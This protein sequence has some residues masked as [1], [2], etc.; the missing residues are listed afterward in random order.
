MR[1]MPASLTRYG[2]WGVVC[3]AS[4]G[5][6]AAF[7]EALAAGG[8]NVLLLARRAE[9]LERL[10]G[11]LRARFRIEARALACDLADASLSAR[12]T[13]AIPGL[14]VGVGVYNAAYSYPT[15][16]LERPLEDALRV[17]DV[18]IRGPLV[19]VHALGPAM[20]SR[21]R[22]A[23]VLMSSLAGFQGVP[24]R[25]AYAASKAFNTVLGE[26]LW[27]ELRPRGVDVVCSCA[28][29][30]RTPG[31]GQTPS[32][33]V[34]GTLS[35]AEVAA[36]TLDA[37]GHGP[38]VIPGGVNK[39]ASFAMRRLFPRRGAIAVMARAVKGLP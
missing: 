6:G 24:R 14:D 15:P 32:K 5:L 31:S 13:E 33:E 25:A 16:L 21:G 23:L 34:P 7:A 27:A 17:V 2:A 9:L 26:S 39:L 3:G 8:L 37:L 18:N 19:M 20:V 4:E 29:H 30:I 1:A 28:G 36:Q 12:L 22:G 10:A 38:T 35:P 11:D